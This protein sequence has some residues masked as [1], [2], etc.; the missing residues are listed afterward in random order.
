MSIFEDK[1]G[2][3]KKMVDGNT[4]QNKKEYKDKRKD[5]HEIFRQKKRVLFVS[6]LEQME[7]AYNNNETKFYQEVNSIRKGLK[8]QTLL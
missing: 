6:K 4:L 1:K 2:A 7:I 8:L 5:A 3:Y